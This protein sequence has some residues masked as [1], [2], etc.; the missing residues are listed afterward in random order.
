MVSLGIDIST[1][2]I[3][4]GG[5]RDDN[6]LVTKMLELNPAARG[7]RRLVGARMTAHA[8]L[9]AH[10]GEALVIVVERPNHRSNG[11][12]LL[13]LAFCVIEAAQA[14]CPGAIVMDCPPSTWKAQV[15]GHGHADKQAALA[16][17]ADLGHET[18]DDDVADALCLA[19]Y[20][21]ARWRA[22]NPGREA[23]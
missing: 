1:R 19:E 2:R 20:G 17:A 15:L 13:G 14:A 12:A 23:A 10:A 16:F 21:W 3:A 8:A 9:G 18:N 6:T 11:M 4:I 22:S 5:I 7:A